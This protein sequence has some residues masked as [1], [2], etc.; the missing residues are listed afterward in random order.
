M[1]ELEMPVLTDF[2]TECLVAIDADSAILTR[3]NNILHAM[4]SAGV[5]MDSN[6][7]KRAYD[8]MGIPHTQITEIVDTA[9]AALV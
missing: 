4:I 1:P 6:D 8:I 9:N 3:Q 2:D 5:H 7:M